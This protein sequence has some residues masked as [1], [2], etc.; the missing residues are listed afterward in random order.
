VFTEEG[1]I[2]LRTTEFGDD[3][4]RVLVKSDGSFAYFASDIAY[5]TSKR[6]RGFDLCIYLLGADHHGYIARLKAAAGCAGDDPEKN[7]KV[8]IGQ[9]VKII[10]AGAELKL[11]KRAGTIITLAEL[12]EKVGVDAARYTLMR[13]PTDT[14]MVLDVDLLKK[15][16]NDNPVYY[17]QYAHARICAMLRNAKDL[18]VT[19]LKHPIANQYLSLLGHER[20]IDL[21]SALS[22]FPEVVASS[23]QLLQPHRICRYLEDLAGIYHRFY[24]DC[25]VLPVGEEKVSELHQMRV[26]L[27]LAT[28]Q[29][30]KNGLT[31][32]GVEAPERM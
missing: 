27:S 11:S 21:L 7:I 31:L 22:K 1:A 17:V 3:K 2:W 30:I 16:T 19:V 9:M 6:D 25:R 5:Y 32:I 24:N 15:H 13:Y 18:S 12:V 10:E 8:L 28:A 20:E 4:D 23:A 29:V 26:T 14:P